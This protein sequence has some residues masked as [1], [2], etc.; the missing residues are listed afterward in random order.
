MRH[1][2]VKR[3]ATRRSLIAATLCLGGCSSFSPFAKND[4]PRP[5]KND[6]TTDH[7]VRYW[8]ANCDR[9]ESLRCDK[10][11]IDVNSQ[12]Q[13]YSLD[14]RMAYQRD[15]RFRLLGTFM[16]KSEVDLGSSEK[17]I[18]FWIARANPPSVY[19]CDRADLPH[20]KLSMPF[21]PDWLVEVLGVAPVD[22]ELYKPGHGNAGYFS[23]VAHEKS[24]AGV[25]ITKRVIVNRQTNRISAFELFD[26]DNKRLMEAVVEEYHDDPQLGYFVPQRIRIEWPDAQTRLSIAMRP[27]KIEFNTITPDIASRLFRR[28]EYTD[29]E[30]VN[31]ADI[32]RER[33]HEAGSGGRDY[34]LNQL[35]NP[36]PAPREDS[37]VRPARGGASLTGRI[38]PE[39]LAPLTAPS[40]YPGH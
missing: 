24:P 10:V 39:A 19:F 14:A 1:D 12:G 23:L 37:R 21:Q 6:G 32:D 5:P 34:S 22:P 16:G 40:F 13:S 26:S 35:Q 8:N 7:F 15:R 30:V 29:T 25:P 20:V 27:R 3:R 36:R 38:E 11:D 4:T 9:I 17:E 18:W 33:R 31:L 28:G 2:W